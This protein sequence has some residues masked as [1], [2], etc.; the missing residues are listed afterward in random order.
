M[1]VCYRDESTYDAS[2]KPKRGKMT[3][4]LNEQNNS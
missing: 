1:V 2:E 3:F 4:L